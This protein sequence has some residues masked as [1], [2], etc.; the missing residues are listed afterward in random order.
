MTAYAQLMLNSAA[1]WQQAADETYACARHA[2]QLGQRNT[3]WRLAHRAAGF[4]VRAA[5]RL[6]MAK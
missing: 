5:E 1:M 2:A 6:A 4:A 3:A